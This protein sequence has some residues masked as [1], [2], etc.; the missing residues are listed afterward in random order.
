MA[1]V[2]KQLLGTETIVALRN[3]GITC[4]IC[5]LSANDKEKEFLKAGADVFTIKPFPCEP[6]AL[7]EELHRIVY[8]EES[9][10]SD[11]DK[12]MTS[13]EASTDL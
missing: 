9:S 2:E 10:P 13:S 7:T 3:K 5:G 6:R 1:S 4:R 12:E 11:I 8:S